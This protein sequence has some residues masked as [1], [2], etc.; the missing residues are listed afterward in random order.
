[1]FEMSFTCKH[2]KFRIQDF[3][4]YSEVTQLLVLLNGSDSTIFGW[5]IQWAKLKSQKVLEIS[6]RM[7]LVCRRVEEFSSRK[8]LINK[9]CKFIFIFTY[10][11]T[12]GNSGG[13]MEAVNLPSIKKWKGTDLNKGG[14]WKIADRR[15]RGGIMKNDFVL[16]YRGTSISI[17]W[18]I[19]FPKTYYYFLSFLFPSRKF[20]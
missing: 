13:K 10:F 1:M 6:T 5:S 11:L 3:Q 18:R 16:N 2:S 4:E 17:K 14:N 12:R 19:K 20:Q 9:L 7:G 8:T 15:G